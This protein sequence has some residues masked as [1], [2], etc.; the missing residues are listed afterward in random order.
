MH[1]MEDNDEANSATLQRRVREEADRVAVRRL[2]IASAVVLMV[3]PLYALLDRWLGQPNVGILDSIKLVTALVPLPAVLFLRTPRGTPWAHPVTF[4]LLI[5][6]TLASS[7]SAVLTGDFI[8]HDMLACMTPLFT[9]ALIPWGLGYQLAAI[10]VLATSAVVVTTATASSPAFL[11]GYPALVGL[12]TWVT[13][14][15][16]AREIVT[17]IR[18]LV[19]QDLRRSH[20]QARLEEEAHVSAALAHAGR[21]L[22]ACTERRALLQRLCELTLELLPC[23]CSWNILRDTPTDDYRITAT[24]GIPAEVSESTNVLK[25]PA[26]DLS[27]LV[28]ELRSGPVVRIGAASSAI[29]DRFRQRIGVHTRIYAPLWQAGQLCGAHVAAFRQPQPASPQ[30]KRLLVGLGQLVS[31]A[32]E[33]N[34][35]IEELE[36]A[37]R[38]KSDFVASMSHE[39]R[40]PLNVILGYHDM[41]L[42]HTLGDLSAEQ[43]DALRRANK[44]ARELLD[45]ISATLDLSRMDNRGPGLS[46]SHVAVQPLFDE[47]REEL[48]VGLE[49]PQLEVQWRAQEDLPELHTDRVKLRMVLK[50]LV[51]NAIKFTP[52]GSIHIGTERDSDG[53][54]FVVADTGIGIAADQQ[55]KIFDA[56]H[57]VEPSLSFAGVGLGLHIVQ[58]LAAALGGRVEFTSQLGRGTTF[59]VWIPIRVA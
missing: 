58:R 47:L 12:T 19:E 43:S 21:E 9:G 27:I 57:Q 41:L 13:S 29:L 24:A 35:L 56:F 11:L 20:T 28:N 32:L 26:K 54:W 33:T 46:L 38:F 50:N 14:L 22:I 44:N 48:K 53:V 45:L 40:T 18:A 37:S 39:L 49:N 10:T 52:Q 1:T 55:H 17:T 5:L 6:L 16:V 25:V 36:R 3:L 34:R 23:D 42:D 51:H 7:V 30:Q 2:A 4:S 31:L 59:R 8:A 15:Y